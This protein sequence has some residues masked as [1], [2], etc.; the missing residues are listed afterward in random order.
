[1]SASLVHESLLERNVPRMYI[2]T[3]TKV[4]RLEGS[5]VQDFVNNTL[6]PKEILFS[7]GDIITNARAIPL[8][9]SNEVVEG[10]KVLIFSLELIYNN[11][12]YYQPIR[13]NDSDNQTI[14][15]KYG[16]SEL[17]FLPV[18]GSYTDVKLAGGKSVISINPS[19][20]TIRLDSD[21]GGIGINSRSGLLDIRN[22]DTSLK[23]VLEKI[24]SS[25]RDL[26]VLTDKGPAGI[27]PDTTSNLLD[28]NL[29][30][31]KLLGPVEDT[32]LFP[33]VPEDT[34]SVEYAS[35]IVNDL[36]VNILNDHG[37][38]DPPSLITNL[39]NMFPPDPVIQPS[40]PSEIPIISTI[41]P[42]LT[43]RVFPTEEECKTYDPTRDVQLSPNFKL[44]SVSTKALFPHKLKSQRGLNKNDIVKNLQIVCLNILEPIKARYPNM[45][46]NSGFRGN[47]SL[48][49]GRVS[50]HETGQAVDLQFVG[51]NFQQYFDAAE[52]VIQNVAF[53][54]F[55]F[56]HGKSIWFHISCKPQSGTNR[57]NILTML[58]NRYESGIK[59]YY[60]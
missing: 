17:R 39:Q 46:I 57:A 59:L 20:G 40:N 49:G 45:R 42:V 47:P 43:P 21:L 9:L 12:F 60:N 8:E 16:N 54:Q 56:E 48:S 29:E 11:T 14:Y 4:S 38:P 52:W 53:D 26:K 41:S 23:E 22:D 37:D 7:V 2:G 6:N 13:F 27:T 1:M 5:P 18:D 35:D 25:V 50:Q 31:S 24:V 44:S 10:N 19:Q 51:F 55:I 15:M 32:R 33:H 58:N 34:Y 3:V 30:I 36:G 28:V